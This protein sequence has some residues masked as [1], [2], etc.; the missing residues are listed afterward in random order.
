MTSNARRLSAARRSSVSRRDFLKYTGAG[1][2]GAALLPAC[3]GFSGSSSES[4]SNKVILS[5]GSGDTTIEALVKMFNEQQNGKIELVYQGMPTDT[6]AYFDQLRTQFQ[7]GG[8]DID[9]ISGDVI[10]PAQFG[11]NGWVDDLTDQFTEEMQAGFLS[12][13]LEA[14]TYQG[15]VY[16]VPFYT[17][18]GMLYYRKDLMAKS[19]FKAPPKTYDELFSMAKKI[20]A[21]SGVKNGLVYQGANYEGGV[22]DGLE[23]VWAHGGDVLDPN[24]PT[25]IVIDSPEA[26]SGLTTER[27]T[28]EQGIAPED[29]VTFTET[30][31]A[32]IYENGDAAFAR[33]WPYMF[34]EVLGG[35]GKIKV[36]QI[37]VAPLPAGQAGGQGYS[38]L[39]GWNLF[40]NAA[41]EKKE[42]AWEAIKFLTG[43]EAGRI[44]A[45]KGGLL[46]P[47]KATYSDKEVT[48]K[49]P[50]IPLAAQL[51]D[52]IKPRPV[53]PF[54][55]DMSLEMQQQF[56]DSLKGST[57]PQDA[58][59]E[60]Q[61]SLESI[62]NKG[63]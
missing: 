32:P 19:G 20:Q 54:Y 29:V 28:V 42:Q 34:G 58:V 25:K 48:S 51:S 24:D 18:A 52:Q 33:N 60:L 13:P 46:S 9:I 8:G 35:K 44:K 50:V 2:A 15:K 40:I 17:D 23:Y 49:V 38:C 55:S 3:G 30:E 39:G 1:L 12:G 59:A 37:G 63:T 22:C 4:A 27:A 26:A 31:S 7:A 5:H 16:A 57:S 36:D 11:A 43:P 47:L 62:I 41:S 53:S 14:V 10:W 56:N 6:G 61:D 21:D 45:L